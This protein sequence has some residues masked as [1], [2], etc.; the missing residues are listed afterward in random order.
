M[1]NAASG[2]KLDTNLFPLIEPLLFE[3]YHFL[4]P[5]SHAAE[6][7]AIIAGEIFTPT[8]TYT[9]LPSE[10][11]L[12]TWSEHLHALEAAIAAHSHELVRR[13]YEPKLAEIQARIELLAAACAGDDAGLGAASRKLYVDPNEENT[14]YTLQHLEKRCTAVA[15]SPYA[16]QVQSELEQLQAWVHNIPEGKRGESALS[17]SAI[18]K[19]MLDTTPVVSAEEIEQMC[20]A[21]LVAH[22]IPEWRVVVGSAEGSHIFS[23][24]H[25]TRIISVPHNDNLH[26]RKRPMT[27][28][29]AEALIAHEIGTHV[30]RRHNG[31][32]SPLLLLGRGLANYLLGE[33]GL[34][35]YVEQRITGAEDYAG[36]A[37]YLSVILARGVA[38]D[39]PRDFIETHTLLAAYLTIDR[40]AS[41][42]SHEMAVD[43]EQVRA[44]SRERAWSMCLRIFRGTSGTT[45][46][47]VFGKDAVYRDGNI[48]LWQ[49]MSAHEGRLPLFFAGK[50][51][52]ANKAHVELVRELGLPL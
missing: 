40:I 51:D 37:G 12:R 2:E 7:R 8:F 33:E 29:R 47:A 36:D 14:R 46:G 28:L 16:A 22:D 9:R 45:P 30:V 10:E 43:V 15:A 34:A 38:D 11:M 26:N 35:T 31:E 39:T 3:D 6:K 1:W 19:P 18:P 13:A 23:V 42:L 5:R 48:A 49:E 52:P 41:A 24:N 44:S 27:K 4:V 25:E 32:Q 17:A 21:A 20:V 50:Y